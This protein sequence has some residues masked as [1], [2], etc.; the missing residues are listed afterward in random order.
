[1]SLS[2][3][4]RSVVVA[5][6][7]LVV[8]SAGIVGS[9]A[10]SQGHVGT[11]RVV[12][13]GQLVFAHPRRVGRNDLALLEDDL[14]TPTPTPAPTAVSPPPP[15]APRPAHPVPA[16]APPVS[17]L[18]GAA[19]VEFSLVNQDRA[20]NA[21]G[22]L[23]YSASLTRVAQYRAQDMLN[24]NYFSHYDPST[25]QLAFLE[26]FRQWG[27]GYATAGENIAWS[28]NPSMAGINTMFMNS[29]EHRANIL[30]PAYHRLGIGVA[31][32]GVKTMVVEVFSN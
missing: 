23:A 18:S 8:A 17:P 27:I 20:A 26:L 32:N 24:R 2:V 28:T 4:R 7:L 14:P 3:T 19:G 31:T 5:V 21:V 10:G 9:L 25:G 30:N 29:P 13:H 15:I 1:M 6:P 22:S 16:P 11:P 12:V